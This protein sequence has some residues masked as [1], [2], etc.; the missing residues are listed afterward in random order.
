ML[1]AE[2]AGRY[3]LLQSLAQDVSKIFPRARV[4]AVA[5][6]TVDTELY[7]KQTAEHNREWYWRD[8]EAT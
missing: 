6:G 4:N 2:T 5:P 1:T 3:G 7:K 8:C